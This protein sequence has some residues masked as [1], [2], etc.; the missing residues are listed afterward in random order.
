[1]PCRSKRDFANGIW[2]YLQSEHVKAA[3]KISDTRDLGRVVK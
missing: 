2:S 3:I 1:M